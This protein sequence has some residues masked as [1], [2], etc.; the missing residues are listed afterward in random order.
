MLKTKKKQ[1]LG[2]AV[3]LTTGE[4]LS[5]MIPSDQSSYDTAIKDPNLKALTTAP[6]PFEV[7]D[8]KLKKFV[9][10]LEGFRTNRINEVTTEH[11]NLINTNVTYNGIQ[12]QVTGDTKAR[13]TAKLT[14]LVNGGTLPKNFFWV[15]SDNSHQPFA[16][17]D[18]QGLLDV[19]EVRETDSFLKFQ[20]RKQTIRHAV[21]TASMVG[22]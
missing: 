16:N 2:L 1:P 22:I 14:Y 15:A 10:D 7:W 11:Y 6:K 20:T 8:V 13:L 18:L 19:I 4:L 5:W 17:A 12:Y 21:D 3:D 9:L